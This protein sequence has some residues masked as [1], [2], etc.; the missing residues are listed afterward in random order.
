MGNKSLVFINGLKDIL[1]ICLHLKI[2]NHLL[3]RFQAQF[4]DILKFLIGEMNISAKK[5]LNQTK[6]YYVKCNFQTFLM[7]IMI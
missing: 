1:Q 6:I 5:Y 7:Q 2:L 3:Q 4:P